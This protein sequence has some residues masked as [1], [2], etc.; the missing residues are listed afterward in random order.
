MSA[1]MRLARDAPDDLDAGVA[2]GSHKC[3]TAEVRSI[4]CVQRLRE[5]RNGPWRFDLAF[6]QP[7]GLVVY[8]MQQGET[9]RQTRRRRHREVKPRFVQSQ[10]I[11]EL[12]KP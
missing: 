2:A 9:C 7:D 3:A 1:V 8:R 10:P 4:V 12:E 11:E 5:T 6:S